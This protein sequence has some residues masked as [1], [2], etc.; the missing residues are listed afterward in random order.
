MLIARATRHDGRT[1]YI[2]KANLP[3][4][5]SYFELLLPER[6]PLIKES[7]ALAKEIVADYDG[8]RWDQLAFEIAVGCCTFLDRGSKSLTTLISLMPDGKDVTSRVSADIGPCACDGESDSDIDVFDRSERTT[9]SRSGD[10]SGR[11][12]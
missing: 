10:P 2:G 8:V 7:V 5:D 11:I 1:Y 9:Y 4:A 12:D 6:A 3:K